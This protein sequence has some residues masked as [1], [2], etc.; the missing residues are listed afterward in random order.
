MKPN[1]RRV[2]LFLLLTSVTF[3]MLTTPLRASTQLLPGTMNVHWDEGAS[4]CAANSQPPLQVH[5]YN[6]QTFILREN[7]CATFEAPFMYLLIGSQKALLIDTGDIE[8][9]K[10]IPLARTIMGLLPGDESGKLPLLVVHT[11]RH[12]DHRAG[13]SQFSHLAN[14]QV[15]G[16]DI[17]SVRHFY[18]FSD[19]PNGLARIDVGDR[20][21]DAIATPGHNETEVSFYDRNTGLFFSGDFLM[22]A[23]LLI[24]DR[25]ADIA[26]AERVAAFVRD[27]PVS[28]VL[29]GHIEMNASGSLFPWES[30]FHRQEHVLQMSKDDL[31]ALPAVVRS[32][33]GFYTTTG[34]FTMMDSMRILIAM[35]VAAGLMLIAIVWILV[36][37]TRRY[38]R[39]RRLRALSIG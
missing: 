29:G 33:N 39:A 19:W 1:N 4:D 27:R 31:L 6:Q 2:G 5:A 26:S 15:V 18:H 23:R 30:Q 17:D 7:L 10:Q 11:H 37:Y 12:L 35:C 22:P 24:D 25:S 14:V 32:F 8:D 21:L 28:Y 20:T 9:P 3:A 38:I 13:D 16:F 34:Q 36:H